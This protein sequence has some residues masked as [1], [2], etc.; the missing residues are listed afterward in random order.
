MTFC[1]DVMKNEK[2]FRIDD[3]QA[4]RLRPWVKEAVELRLF[5]HFPRP[6]FATQPEL[7][8]RIELDLLQGLPQRLAPVGLSIKGVDHVQFHC[9][10]GSEV[11][12][13]AA[14]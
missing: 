3:P 7:R 10:A 11:K 2:V 14:S 1:T 6:E 5:G 9:A 12:R 4:S 13:N 8:E